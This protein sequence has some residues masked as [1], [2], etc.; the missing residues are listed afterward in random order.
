MN[1][2]NQKPNMKTETQTGRVNVAPSSTEGHFVKGA[3]QVINLDNVNETFLVEGRA[4]LETKNHTLP[5]H[6]PGSLQ[7][8]CKDVFKVKRLIHDAPP[9]THSLRICIH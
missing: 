2:N 6:V 7:S 1:T 5:D 4:V 8:V 9:V 3:K